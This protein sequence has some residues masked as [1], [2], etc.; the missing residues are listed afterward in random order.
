M[1]PLQRGE[2]RARVLRC[3]QAHSDHRLA[4]DRVRLLRHR[5][6]RAAMMAALLTHLA[7][8]WA[9]ELD[10]LARNP[11]AKTREG[12]E[13]EA[14]FADTVARGVPRYVDGAEAE[15]TSHR[16]PDVATPRSECCGRAGRAE[17]LDDGKA[18]AGGTQPLAVANE[19][20]EP[21][22]D[23]APKR[24]RHCG[25]PLRSARHH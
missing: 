23:L 22:G 4:A 10:D 5:G 14:G 2:Q 16:M 9:G 18:R 15:P 7:D 21:D 19:L 20:R 1:R 17:Q 3:Q 25:L 24:N 6:R 8:L 11:A 13:C 12:G